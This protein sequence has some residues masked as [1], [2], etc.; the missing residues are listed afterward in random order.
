MEGLP[1]MHKD[2]GSRKIRSSTL[3]WASLRPILRVSQICVY[4]NSEK[5]VFHRFVCVY[6]PSLREDCRLRL[7][8]GPNESLVYERGSKMGSPEL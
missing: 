7:Q 5:N 6:V 1:G 8:Q 3:S 2:R 4:E